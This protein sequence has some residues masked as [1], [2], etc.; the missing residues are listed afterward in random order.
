M[1][2]LDLYIE[3]KELVK[4]SKEINARKREIK[5]RLGSVKDFKN[6]LYAFKSE[7]HTRARDMA[8]MY[9]SGS[10]LQEIGDIY[11]ITRERV[12]QILSGLGID[13]EKGGLAKKIEIAKKTP[14]N[15]N[16]CKEF[17]ISQ[18]GFCQKHQSMLNRHGTL[19]PKYKNEFQ[20]N[21]GVCLV[22]SCNEPF[23]SNGLCKKHRV[24]L[25]INKTK[26]N[27]DDLN[28]YL[29]VQKAKRLM[30]KKQ[31]EYSKIREFMDKHP[32]HFKEDLYVRK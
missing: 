13:K 28:D 25:F 4:K 23:A 7:N 32:E 15:A 9:T 10:T 20:K 16:G 1:E 24:N 19:T 22:D 17:S 2:K 31:V 14:C 27:V 8:E 3:W 30:G 12:R 6:D 26:G 29:K 21:S 11:G 5:D 18:R